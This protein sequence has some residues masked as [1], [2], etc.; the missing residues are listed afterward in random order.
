MR[1]FY[2]EVEP[3][4]NSS[5]SLIHVESEG[6]T[7]RS[8]HFY[9]RV[10]RYINNGKYTYYYY[11][12]DSSLLMCLFFSFNLD[13]FDSAYDK[14]K[15]Y[16][17]YAR[18]TW[19]MLCD[20]YLRGKQGDFKGPFIYKF[21]DF[22]GEDNRTYAWLLCQTVPYISPNEINNNE[23]YEL[24]CSLIQYAN[25]MLNE[26]LNSNI[27]T[28]DKIKINLTAAGKIFIKEFG[29]EYFKRFD[30]F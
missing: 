2:R 14:Y 12:L 9:Y 30:I 25:D 17:C 21:R 16:F 15:E 10:E 29:K 5:S 24:V 20:A 3:Y 22:G 28:L 23:Q 27:S 13:E 11:P 19:P 4:E 8:G 1:F 7:S 26:F 6:D 18:K